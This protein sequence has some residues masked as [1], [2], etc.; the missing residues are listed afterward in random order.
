MT[1]AT[2]TPWVGG[3]FVALGLGAALYG[4][5][6][7]AHADAADHRPD[8]TADSAHSTP[9][10]SG[11]RGPT[12]T[13]AEARLR[14]NPPRITAA[15]ARPTVNKSTPATPVDP[16]RDPTTA[17]A[18]AAARRQPGSGV[19]R[20]APRPP[21]QPAPPAPDV[22][23]MVI[24]W[25]DDVR[26]HLVGTAP[27]RPRPGDMTQTPYGDIG[28]WMLAP[29]GGVAD[30]P[31]QGYPLTTLYQP[32]NV[33]IVDP[34]STTAAES[35]AKLNAALAAAGFPAQQIHAS[36]YRGVINGISY[37]QQPAGTLEAFADAHW[38]LTNDHGRVFGP[39]PG[40]DGTGF[41]WTAS[42]SRERTGLVY[43]VP[44]HVY[45]SFSRARNAVRDALVANGATDLG[46]VD[47]DNKLSGRT[48]TG[49]HDGDAVVIRLN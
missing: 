32:I 24:T 34:T 40:P 19:A 44:T 3:L 6:G 29:T 38:L 18:L 7:I 49:D 5:Q 43:I 14:V 33:I 8:R 30:W 2:P 25:L 26:D 4:G 42:F 27:V 12:A 36:G 11:H 16:P 47:L 22:V 41:V 13:S 23:T 48:T 15:G 46:M 9:R 31:S 35:A 37:G 1:A 45:V 28:K 17:A 20:P 21:V 39:A 10:A